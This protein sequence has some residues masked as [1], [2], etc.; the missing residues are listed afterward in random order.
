MT[1][2]EFEQLLEAKDVPQE[3]ALKIAN[4]L[5][6]APKFSRRGRIAGKL[7][8]FAVERNK[9]RVAK[10][11]QNE[12]TEVQEAKVVSP[13]VRQ[14][15]KNIKDIRTKR[16]KLARMVVQS[17]VGPEHPAAKQAE[18]AG[19]RADHLPK[20]LRKE[21]KEELEMQEAYGYRTTASGRKVMRDEPDETTQLSQSDQIAKDPKVIAQRRASM[22]AN[23]KAK[24]KVPTKGGKPMFEEIV[25]YLF[26]EGFADTFEGAELMAESISAEWVNDIMEKL[27]HKFPLSTKEKELARRIGERGRGSEEPKAPRSARK[28]ETPAQPPRRKRTTDLSK[29]IVAHYLYNE[30]YADT[31]ESAEEMAENI[32]EEWMNDILDEKY[33]KAMDTTGKGADRRAHTSDLKNR[34]K[35]RK[36]TPEKYKHSEAEFDSTLRSPSARKRKEER[37]QAVGGFREEY[38]EIDEAAKDQ[39]DKQINKGVKTTYKAGNVLDNLHQGRSRGIE[40][41]D[42]R[43]RD[44]KVERMRGRLKT[45]RDDLFKERGNRE[46]AKRA[47]LKKLLGL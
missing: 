43:D 29:V 27:A 7:R 8:Q 20:Y 22:R 39:S 30:G 11:Q 6:G 23:L 18:R 3:V 36:P 9:K 40:K 14:R 33:V 45:R 46:D 28:V 15:A 37:R 32:S 17:G 10:L 13:E 4:A 16:Q 31:M 35:R 41:M 38:E 1:D 12:E 34:P 25:E 19:V 21:E 42:A 47:E 26:V 5:K 24:G 2:E 44:A